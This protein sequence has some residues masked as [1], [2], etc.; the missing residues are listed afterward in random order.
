MSVEDPKLI[1]NP[2][3]LRNRKDNSSLFDKSAI[4]CY[5]EIAIPVLAALFVL[6]GMKFDQIIIRLKAN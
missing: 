5:N 4:D 2:K 6:N 1:R 3:K